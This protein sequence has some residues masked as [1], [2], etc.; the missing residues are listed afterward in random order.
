MELSNRE[1]A[2]LLD[3]LTEYDE[4][5]CPKELA[6]NE[7]GLNAERLDDLVKRLKQEKGRAEALPAKT[8][9]F[10]WVLDASS[11]IVFKVEIPAHF[12][13]NGDYEDFLEANLPNDI[14]LKDCN[15]MVGKGDA[16]TIH[17]H[18]YH[19]GF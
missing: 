4:Q 15:W 17:R 11:G 12:P 1:A 19:L 13:E 18:R 5:I 14:R 8:D 2:N 6:D 3:A 10:I 16:V 7:V 9:E